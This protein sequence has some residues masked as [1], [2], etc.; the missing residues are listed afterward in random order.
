[1]PGCTVTRVALDLEHAVHRR[2][3]ELRAAVGGDAA[4]RRAAGADRAH[5]ASDSASRRISTCWISL[6]VVDLDRD[7]GAD[8]E[9]ASGR[10]VRLRATAV[11]MRGRT[12][13]F[14]VPPVE[15]SRMGVPRVQRSCLAGNPAV[16]GPCSPVR[17]EALCPRLSPGLPLI[18]SADYRRVRVSS[19]K[20]LARIALRATCSV[21]AAR[22]Y[23][24]RAAPA[25][26][27]GRARRRGSD[28]SCGARR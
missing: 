23:V 28:R 17:P 11:F 2:Q 12:P 15:T 24:N 13:Y 6:G 19:C 16:V 10:G 1:M 5:R 18:S 20:R 14:F 27:R 3:I 22:D 4:R 9:A 8:E 7:R 21:P 25:D 26:G